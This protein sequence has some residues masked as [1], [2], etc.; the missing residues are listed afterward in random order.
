MRQSAGKESVG[1]LTTCAR[2]FF[3]ESALRL[4]S[5]S[6]MVARFSSA[7]ASAPAP[8]SSCVHTMPVSCL[9]VPSHR[10]QHALP[11]RLLQYRNRLSQTAQ[12]HCG[13][14]LVVESS[15]APRVQRHGPGKVVVRILDR[16]IVSQ[17]LLHASAIEGPKGSLSLSPIPRVCPGQGSGCRGTC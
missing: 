1:W 15:H 10:L 7:L 16:P 14:R 13:D 11:Y 4:D 5:S 17:K 2:R 3:L 9:R 6:Y 12:V 8:A